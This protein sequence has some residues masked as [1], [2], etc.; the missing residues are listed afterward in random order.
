MNGAGIGYLWL[1]EALGGKLR[2]ENCHRAW[3]LAPL[4]LARS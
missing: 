3:M 4:L 1:V 2:P